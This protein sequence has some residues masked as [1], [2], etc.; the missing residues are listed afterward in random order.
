MASE[1][2]FVK[3][4]ELGLEFCGTYALPVKGALSEGEDVPQKKLYNRI[5]LT[6]KER[7]A[8]YLAHTEGVF[9]QRRF[10]RVLEYIEDSSASPRE[11]LLFLLL[12]LPYRY[13]GYGF[14]K[15]DLNAKIMPAK[16]AKETS[17]K[18][19]FRCDLFWSELDV[20]VEYESDLA[21]LTPQQIASDSKKRNSLAAM[22]IM[23]ITV[24][25][26]QISSTVE[27]ERVAKQLAVNLD[28][29]LRNNEN[30]RFIKV[31]RELRSLLGV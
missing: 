5:P 23:V 7:L 12:T 8:T 31:R 20:A 6:N 28:R 17:S 26:K 25:N 21:H 27:F 22:G 19:F 16:T 3:L 11:T 30:P 15:P 9:G 13:G 1:L 14:P 18:T 2:P 4:L 10:S 29:R 24:T